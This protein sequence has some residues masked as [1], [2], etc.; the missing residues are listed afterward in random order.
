MFPNKPIKW[1][2][3]YLLPHKVTYNTYLQ[4]VQY[5][6]SNNILYLNE[7]LYRSKLTNSHLSS[8]C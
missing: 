8:F 7:K 2:E 5:K 6:V 3:I 4:C 1:H